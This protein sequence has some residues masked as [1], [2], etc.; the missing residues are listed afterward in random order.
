MAAL[1]TRHDAFVQVLQQQHESETGCL[2]RAL[3]HIADVSRNAQQLMIEFVKGAQ[4]NVDCV[5]FDQQAMMQ[6][7]G[8]STEPD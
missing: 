7:T 6:I 1:E 8:H 5:R 2:T 3:D 4:G